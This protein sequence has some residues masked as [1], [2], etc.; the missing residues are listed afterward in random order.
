VGRNFETFD[1]LEFLA[2]LSTHIPARNRKV[3]IYY[4]FYFQPARGKRKKGGAGSP[5]A[6]PLSSRTC[7]LTI[8]NS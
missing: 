7:R 3:V 5:L 2:A 1:T 4:G 8:N 6:V